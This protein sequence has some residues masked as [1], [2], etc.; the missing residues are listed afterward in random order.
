MLKSR[1]PGYPI[2]AEVGTKMSIDEGRIRLLDADPGLGEGLPPEIELD[3]RDQLVADLLTLR[4]GEWRPADDEPDGHLGYLVLDGLLTREV[5]VGKSRSV[6][7]LNV[8]DLLRPWQED[9]SSYSTSRWAALDDVSL[10]V[11]GPEVARRI[12]RHPRIVSVLVERTMCRARNL[13]V[14]WAIA[15]TV[16]LETRILMLFRHLAERWG[17]V[18]P[19]GI[20]V[21]LAI[22]HQIVADLVGARRPSATTAIVRLAEAGKLSRTAEGGW[23]LAPA[24]PG[25]GPGE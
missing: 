13:A 14:H 11:L 21:P 19:E 18:T 16:G 9:P 25:I 24:T 23:L 2:G 15:N 20:A 3:A 7:L 5:T 1:P 4:K 10:A 17:K 6:E 8:G 22:T 12:G